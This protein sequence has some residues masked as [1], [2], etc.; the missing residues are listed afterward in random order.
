VAVLTVVQPSS[1]TNG[2]FE[3]GTA[4]WTVTGNAEVPTG[5]FYAPTD[6]TRNAAFNAGQS[7]PNGVISQTVTTTSGQSYTLS[8][9]VGVLA[10]NFNEQRMQ[11]TVQGSTTLL[12]TTISL[13]GDGTG[14]TRWTSRSFPITANSSATTV[15]FRDVSPGT[16]NLDLTLDKVQFIPQAGGA[17]LQ[18]LS[19]RPDSRLEAVGV[20]RLGKAAIAR[21]PAGWKITGFASRSGT[22]RLE[23]SANL[24]SWTPLS[25]IST[26]AGE[27]L[28]FEDREAPGAH[29][30]YRIVPAEAGQAPE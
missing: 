12:N 11:V 24:D 1:F 3:S 26:A 22:Y 20:E 14:N 30:F 23:H 21:S 8:F 4:G 28:Q 15:T 10:F 27:V 13:F 25:E 17:G 7:T 6:G 16:A 5:T 29:G 9:D 19:A 18:S 2:S